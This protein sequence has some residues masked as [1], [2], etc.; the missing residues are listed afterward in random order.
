[1]SSDPEDTLIANL[2]VT[3]DDVASTGAAADSAE[4]DERLM[5][6]P[7]L[8]RYCVLHR[9]HGA[10]CRERLIAEIA[11]AC[12]GLPANLAWANNKTVSAASALAAELDR[13]AVSDDRPDL[14]SLADS[15]RALSL[16]ILR[17]VIKLKEH[18]RVAKGLLQ[19]Q[20]A[21]PDTLDSDLV[22]DIEAL[23]WGWAALPSAIDR[24]P[25]YNTSLAL[26]AAFSLGKLM[27]QHRVAH[28][29]QE[30]RHKYEE[31]QGAQQKETGADNRAAGSAD[32]EGT[33]PDGHVVVCR[34]DE[35]AMKNPKMREVVTPYKAV[36]NTALPLAP[37]PA[38]HE[39]RARLLFEFPYAESVIDF[40]LTDLVGR[41]TVKLRNLLLVGAAGCGKS[42]FS[43]VM[44]DLLG[45]SVWRVDASRSDGAVFGGT[46][47]RWYSAEP[48]HPFLAVA[49][50]GI[51]NP[52][53]LI[54]EIEKAATR[55]DYGRFWDCLLGFLEPET[56]TRYPD[57]AL[58]TAL[59]LSHV[60]YI[61]TANSLDPLPGPIRDRFRVIE[62]PMPTA[63]DVDALLPAVLADLAAERGLD[64]R[65]IATLNG[66]ERDA[67]SRFWKGGSVRRLR[68]VV[69]AVLNARDQTAARN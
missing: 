47:K 15:V 61:A 5:S 31:K 45:V 4:T 46:D 37:V 34:L 3:E 64:R 41:S 36:I 29:E 44:G 12:P 58:Q 32:V 40:A 20:R 56:A 42:R 1:M 39:I 28:A 48:A 26:D 59:D 10:F 55:S 6:L 24:L 30:V 7:R 62:F 66:D 49:Q 21:L 2:P 50:G 11:E 69:E 68:L 27:A 43:R 18:R 67:V 8:L 13:L 57:P 25:G 14:R 22:S 23:V 52:L 54:D 60:S 65:W 17:N 63:S 33:V 35:V 51:A 16:A 19:A 9:Q 38:L 53:V